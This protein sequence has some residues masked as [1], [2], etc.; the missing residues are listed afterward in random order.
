MENYCNIKTKVSRL[1]V[2]LFF[3]LFFVDLSAGNILDDQIPEPD[4]IAFEIINETVDILTKKYPLE[5]CGTGMNGKFEY[6]EISFEV[7]KILDRQKAREMLID[8]VEIFLEKIN[9]N[10]KIQPYLIAKPF[11]FENAGIVFFIRDEKNNRVFHP[12]ITVAACSSHGISFRTKEKE[13]IFQY[14]EVYEET[15]EE[16]LAH[17]KQSRKT[18]QSAE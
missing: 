8:C 5:L 14:K 18:S 6:L 9:T 2:S 16:A 17:L 7:S 15:H 12:A 13:N 4:R 3:L 10:E 1:L 11:T